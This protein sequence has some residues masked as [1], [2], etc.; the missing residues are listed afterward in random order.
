MLSA[1]GLIVCRQRLRPLR[2][3][4]RQSCRR[5]TNRRPST[6]LHRRTNHHANRCRNCV[7]AGCSCGCCRTNGC[8]RSRRY[9]CVRSCC[10]SCGPTSECC[11]CIG[12]DSRCGLLLL[13]NSCCHD[14]VCLLRRHKSSS[15][16]NNNSRHNCSRG[17]NIHSM[18]RSSRHNSRAN[19]N[20]SRNR[21]RPNRYTNKN[22][23][24]ANGGHNRSRMGR[25]NPNPNVSSR[26]RASRHSSRRTTDRRNG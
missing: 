19:A 1:N 10:H 12:N 24:R 26:S 17:C 21:D 22:N 18:G 6:N 15:L 4:R 25:T 23:N 2:M 20:R 7:W 9:C 14:C 13:A 8:Y 5:Q 16:A 11:R 3:N